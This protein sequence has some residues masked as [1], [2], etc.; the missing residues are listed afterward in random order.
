MVGPLGPLCHRS[1]ETNE[2]LR[3]V[4]SKTLVLIYKYMLQI[5]IVFHKLIHDECY[6]YISNEILDKYFTFIAVNKDIPKQYNPYRYKVI[7]EW[8]LPI[9]DPTF[10]QRGYNENSAIYHI[11]V[12]KLHEKYKYIGFFQ[13]DMMF[14]KNIQKI[15]KS[16]Q[17]SSPTVFYHQKF[18][19]DFC[20]YKTWNEPTTMEFIIKDYETYFQKPL[21]RTRDFPLYNSFILPVVLFEKIMPWILTLYDKLYPWCVQPPNKTHFAHL[22]GIYERIMGFAIGNEDYPLK[23]IEVTHNHS[24]KR[25]AY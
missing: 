14:G 8:E 19:F 9:Y 22:G 24:I 1:S 10:Q 7:K 12:N 25:L 2:Y 11:F 5:F 15:L 23:P 3:V 17:V 4:A 16:I 13:Y 18:S 20:C 21:D 6:K